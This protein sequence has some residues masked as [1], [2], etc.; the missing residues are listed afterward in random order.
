M[1]L[2]WNKKISCICY[3]LSF[4]LMI[5]WSSF[6]LCMHLSPKIYQI[7]VLFIHYWFYLHNP[8][9]LLFLFSLS[10]FSFYFLFLFSLSIF[11]FYLLFLFSISSLFSLFLFSLSILY[12]YI[13]ILISSCEFTFC[14]VTFFLLIPFILLHLFLL[15]SLLLVVAITHDRY[16]LENSCSWIL[17]MDRGE[18]IPYEGMT[19]I[20]SPQL[21]CLFFSL[22]CLCIFCYWMVPDWVTLLRYDRKYDW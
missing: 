16:F 19:T 10:I 5:S 7:I 11:S 1:I 15:Y 9:P 22:F 13:L 4:L 8:Y 21:F 12:F 20:R 14:Q 2:L 17:E 3:F 18:G 6:L